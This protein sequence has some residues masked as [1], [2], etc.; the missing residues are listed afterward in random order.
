MRKPQPHSDTI[1][2]D[3]AVFRAAVRDVK[4]LQHEARVTA[5]ARRPRRRRAS[6]AEPAA[7]A[8]PLA[9][10]DTTPDEVLSFRRPGVQDQSFRKLRRGLIPGQAQVD[11]HGL[12]QQQAWDC[13]QDFIT[14]S[15]DRNLRC[16]RVVHGKGYRSGARGP[17]LK[18]AVNA[19]LRRSHDVVAF[20]SAR[21]IDGGA[22][23]LYV[24]LRA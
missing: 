8:P 9:D 2:P 24:L 22:G 3:A 11:L 18:S 19:W 15:R 12:T 23:A 4:P 14:T 1:T 20:V 17:V 21:A 10:T 16:V 13:L 6:A 5:P 7:L